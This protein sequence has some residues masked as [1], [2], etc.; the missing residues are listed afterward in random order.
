MSVNLVP[1]KTKSYL[2]PLLNCKSSVANY[3]FYFNLYVQKIITLPRVG[4]TGISVSNNKIS[5]SYDYLFF[6]FSHHFYGASG[7]TSV[8]NNRK[9]R[10]RER[11][12]QKQL[13]PR[14]EDCSVQQQFIKDRERELE[15]IH[16]RSRELML[17]PRLM[18][19]SGGLSS[20][21]S[22]MDRSQRSQ[23]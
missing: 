10:S 1:V 18:D 7:A 3:E 9:S 2:H 22:S 19:C 6:R 15:R 20:R 8:V 16:R 12:L 21:D 14:I 4:N 17:S 23:R 13:Q 5:F 11:P